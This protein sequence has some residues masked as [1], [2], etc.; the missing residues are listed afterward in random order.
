MF[1]VDHVE[2]SNTN[3]IQWSFVNW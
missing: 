1:Q 2:N 3:A